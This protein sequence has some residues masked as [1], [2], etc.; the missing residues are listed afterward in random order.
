VLGFSQG[1]ATIARWIAAGETRPDELILWA[2]SFPPEIDLAAFAAK[3]SG[4]S[5]VLV[6]GARDELAPWA[7]AEA[8]CRRM[9]AAGLSARLMTFPGGHRL[10]HGTLEAIAA[11]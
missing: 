2:G 1:V 5:V 11:A 4:A 7:G 3:V 9:M 8:T 10:D 6:V